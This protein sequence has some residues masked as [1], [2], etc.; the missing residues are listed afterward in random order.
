MRK[1]V[2]IEQK[3]E[4][5][6]AEH[7]AVDDS[8]E[9]REDELSEEDEEERFLA[10]R[11]GLGRPFYR[12]FYPRPFFGVIAHALAIAVPYSIDTRHV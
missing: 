2:D 5:P 4:N 9:V 12:P 8:L 10:L 7:E 11:F 3:A 6:E 1:S